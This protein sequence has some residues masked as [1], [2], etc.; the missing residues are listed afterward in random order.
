MVPFGCRKQQVLVIQP[1]L[2]QKD[3]LPMQSNPMN[4]VFPCIQLK[5][6]QLEL[7]DFANSSNCVF[8]GKLEEYNWGF[9]FGEFLDV[10]TVEFHSVCSGIF[11]TIE[12]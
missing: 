9:I 12:F 11:F 3:W 8:W 10:K 7:T 5:I 6:F 2:I 4:F 1:F